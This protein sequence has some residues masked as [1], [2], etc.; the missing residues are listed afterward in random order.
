MAGVPTIKPWAEPPKETEQIDIS[1][2]ST[3]TYIVKPE[4]AGHMV[5]TQTT[6]IAP[7]AV[8]T[9]NKPETTPEKITKAMRA[10]MKRDEVLI[11]K[12]QE[13]AKKKKEEEEELQKSKQEAEEKAQRS[14][15]GH[16]Q[17]LFGMS[18]LS[19]KERENNNEIL[20]SLTP[21]NEKDFLTLAKA[22]VTRVE[23][24]ST[25]ELLQKNYYYTD[26]IKDLSKNIADSASTEDFNEII[27]FVTIILNDKV[28]KN[29]T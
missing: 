19:A 2:P 3:K 24:Y 12:A 28:K 27:H 1:K 17:E 9:E 7:D 8:K 22:V 18:K 16:A 6:P 20:L 13:E 4:I 23:A 21:K 15:Y 26:L 11:A 10:K 5:I 25:I 29:K 14:D